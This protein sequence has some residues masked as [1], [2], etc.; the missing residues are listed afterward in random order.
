VPAGACGFVGLRNFEE[1]V[2]VMGGELKNAVATV[3]IQCPPGK[4]YIAARQQK[5]RQIS[6]MATNSR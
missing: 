3:A 6:Q 2:A 4:K 1:L 5:Y